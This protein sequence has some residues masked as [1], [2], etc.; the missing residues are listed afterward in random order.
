MSVL[1]ASMKIKDTV[2]LIEMYEIGL[3]GTGTTALIEFWHNTMK[4]YILHSRELSNYFKE[5][6][7]NLLH[8]MLK[9]IIMC[10]SV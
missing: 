2:V 3:E 10:V 7:E 5:E 8:F 1:L 6:S 4:R 9:K